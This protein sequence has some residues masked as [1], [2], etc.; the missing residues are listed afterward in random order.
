MF[1]HHPQ[2]AMSSLPASAG[3]MG[4]KTSQLIEAQSYLGQE[5]VSYAITR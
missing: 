1:P 5:T 3:P 4:D 2:A